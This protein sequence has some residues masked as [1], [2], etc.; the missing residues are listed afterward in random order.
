M[1]RRKK[2]KKIDRIKERNEIEEKNSTEA[3]LK[4]AEDAGLI[5]FIDHELPPDEVDEEDVRRTNLSAFLSLVPYT[6]QWYEAKAAEEELDN[7]RKI[8]VERVKAN[9][10]LSMS[11]IGKHDEAL[12]MMMSE[13][14]YDF[15]YFN[16]LKLKMEQEGKFKFEKPE[17]NPFQILDKSNNRNRLKKA[18]NAD[19]FSFEYLL[20][21]E[22]QKKL[23]ADEDP[24]TQPCMWRGKNNLGE[25]LKCDNKRLVIKKTSKNSRNATILSKNK[26]E[27]VLNFCC[28]HVSFC[29]N[30]TAHG[31]EKS[32]INSPNIYSL[33]SECYIL[34]TKKKPVLLT[35]D[36]CHGVTP[37]AL[38]GL[39]KLQK[40]IE[41]QNEE[42]EK[43]EKLNNNKKN[44]NN[45]NLCEWQGDIEDDIKRQYTCTNPLFVDSKNKKIYDF[46]V[47]HVPYCVASHPSNSSSSNTKN[48]NNNKSS[49]IAMPNIYCLCQQ[50][51]IAEF[52]TP[53]PV[54]LFPFPGMKKKIRKD[55]WKTLHG[56]KHWAAPKKPPPRDIFLKKFV[57]IEENKKNNKNFYCFDLKNMIFL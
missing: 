28:Y 45:N 56:K 40:K 26:N 15:F 53:P 43:T 23:S 7:L 22:S 11:K 20:S 36:I 51:Y 42:N 5:Q 48:N 44:K 3:L 17:L 21:S 19:L 24:R 16:K 32:K 38:L 50:H 9:D 33:C 47:W 18:I 29:I 27:E 31:E 10:F 4:K 8:R 52:S 13:T 14:N 25:Q 39:A 2:T 12:D 34:K 49:L 41:N 57:G 1:K 6:N 46:C 30:K 55:F 35:N 37:V 54:V